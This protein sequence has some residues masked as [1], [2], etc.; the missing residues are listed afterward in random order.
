[1]HMNRE[2]VV[3]CSLAVALD[4]ARRSFQ[5]LN[6]R[7]GFPLQVLFKI[8]GIEPSNPVKRSPQF[9]RLVDVDLASLLCVGLPELLADAE[10]V[11]TGLEDASLATEVCST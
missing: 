7:S 3:K 2:S 5:Y 1:M 8:L 10:R 6:P 11:E 4:E 9:A